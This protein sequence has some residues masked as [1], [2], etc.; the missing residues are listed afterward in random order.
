MVPQWPLQT[1]AFPG[2]K[3]TEKERLP[4]PPLLLSLLSVSEKDL[5]KS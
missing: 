5:L 1:Q 4:T 2:R 3:L